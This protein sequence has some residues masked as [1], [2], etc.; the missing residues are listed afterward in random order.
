MIVLDQP[1][2]PDW[3]VAVLAVRMR[4]WMGPSPSSS[5]SR[6]CIGKATTHFASVASIVVEWCR[7]TVLTCWDCGSVWDRTPE[8]RQGRAP[9]VEV[10]PRNDPF[11]PS[12]YHTD[13]PPCFPVCVMAC[14]MLDLVRVVKWLTREPNKARMVG[15]LADTRECCYSR[16]VRHLGMGPP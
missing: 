11:N 3:W 2:E 6:T 1:I 8:G 16:T 4:T 13:A 12:P 14:Q 10:S 7:I 9:A 5:A 15:L